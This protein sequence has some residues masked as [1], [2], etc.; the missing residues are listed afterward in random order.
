MLAAVSGSEMHSEATLQGEQR[1]DVRAP[2]HLQDGRFQY[3]PADAYTDEGELRVYTQPLSGGARPT[4]LTVGMIRYAVHDVVTVRLAS[5]MEPWE[6]GE[7]G[8]IHTAVVVHQRH[9]G[10][11]DVRLIDDLATTV[12]SVHA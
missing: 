11:C 6:H 5:C 1:G 8:E 7:N 12:C 4:R 9:D 2:E 10:S 3:H